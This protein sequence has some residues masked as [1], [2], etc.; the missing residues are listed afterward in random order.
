MSLPSLLSCSPLCSLSLSPQCLFPPFGLSLSHSMC[1]RCTQRL[2]LK[3]TKPECNYS[4][5]Q[6]TSLS[7]LLSII[8]E[9]KRYPSAALAGVC[10]YVCVCMSVCGRVCKQLLDLNHSDR[11]TPKALSAHLCFKPSHQICLLDAHTGPN[12]LTLEGPFT[13][14][15]HTHR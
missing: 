15:T 4:D 9:W 5:P 6:H 13:K 14:H 11:S 8:L 12:T 7:S 3:L 1:V 2:L 10:V